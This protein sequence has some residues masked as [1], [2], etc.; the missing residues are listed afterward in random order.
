GQLASAITH[1]VNTPLAAMASASGTIRA[2]VDMD[3]QGFIEIGCRLAPAEKELFLD[4]VNSALLHAKSAAAMAGSRAKKRRDLAAALE[5]RGYAEAR[6]LADML[7]EMGLLERWEDYEA[8]YGLPRGA[9]LVRHA[10]G[11][12]RIAQSARLIELAL[13]RASAVIRALGS[14]VDAGSTHERSLIDV[15]EEIDTVLALYL[16]S[17]H[18]GVTLSREYGQGCVVLASPDQLIQVWTNLIVNALQAMQGSGSL[19]IRSER[20]GASLRVSIEDNGPGIPKELALKVFEPLFT[21]K[22]DGQGSGLGLDIAK[23]VVESLGGSIS[24][25]S[26]PGRTIFTVTL[27]AAVD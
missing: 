10:Q 5:A 11:F 17:A 7:G 23:R 21:T 8:L 22:T 13:D 24:L 1:Q 14:Y 27:P 9:E 16:S 19:F 2:S 18:G 3:I 25:E 20:L 4:M 12:A 15:N 26:E 6:Q